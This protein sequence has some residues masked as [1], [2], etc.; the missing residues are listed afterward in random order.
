M[1]YIEAYWCAAVQKVDQNSGM[2]F[3]GVYTSTEP[4]P[5][6]GA[7]SY[8]HRFYA[9]PFGSLSQVWVSDDYELGY[10]FALPFTGFFS[11][12][13]GNPLAVPHK[14]TQEKGGKTAPR[15]SPVELLLDGD[16]VGTSN[17]PQNCPRGYSQH[18]MAVDNECEIN[19][20]VKA[21][22]SAKLPNT[23]VKDPL[24]MPALG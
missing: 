6:T 9:M 20:C 17:G 24:T 7:Q 23:A 1:V 8:P 4:D 14:R 15:V 10:Q 12:S 3:G 13:S 2:L 11:C 22:S 16:G 19:Y 21:K 5:V 18:L